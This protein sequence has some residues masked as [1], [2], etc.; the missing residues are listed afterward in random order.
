MVDLSSLLSKPRAFKIW[1]Q[2]EHN[3]SLTDSF[4]EISIPKIIYGTSS[5]THDEGPDPKKTD[6]G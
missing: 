4:V 2:C 3:A 5:T 6:V 1:I